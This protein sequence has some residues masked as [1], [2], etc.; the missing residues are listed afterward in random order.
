[1]MDI[2]ANITSSYQQHIVSVTTNGESK[3]L[4]IEPKSSG[5]GSL[6]N[7]GELLVLALA[8]CYCNDLYREAAKRNMRIDGVHVTCKAKFG[9][10]GDPGS[11]FSYHVEVRSNAP[12]EEIKALIQH[13]DKIAEIHNTLRKGVPVTL[14][15]IR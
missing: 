15:G 8:T 1:M 14:E 12:A 6:V 7:G 13:T 11:S 9:G 2:S 10:E 4:A 5:Y 3:A